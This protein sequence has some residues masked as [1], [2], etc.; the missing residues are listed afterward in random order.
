MHMVQ[1]RTV[2]FDELR[3]RLHVLPP[4]LSR[5]LRLLAHRGDVLL[6]DRYRRPLDLTRRACT[7]YIARAQ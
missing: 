6:L 5:A 4:S 7:R 3:R 2:A 1:T